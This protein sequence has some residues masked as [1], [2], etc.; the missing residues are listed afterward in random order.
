MAA[1]CRPG[2]VAYLTGGG[3]VNPAG[4]LATGG[5]APNGASS[6]ALP[7]SISV[8]GQPAT[9]YYLGLTPG[10][11]GLYQANFGSALSPKVMAS[12]PG[13]RLAYRQLLGRVAAIPGVRS[14]AIT[15]LV[16]L[17]VED[18]EIP[19]WPGAGPQPAQDRTTSAMFSIVTPDYPGA[20]H[21]PLLRGRFFTDQ[22]NLA[23]PPVVA[24][25][26]V[27]ARHVFGDRDLGVA[28]LGRRSNGRDVID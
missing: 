7:Y 22:D 15:S 6:A 4:P 16:P 2:V 14:A 24:I 26:E 21:I 11:V 3:P 28:T 20:M 8:G 1:I 25:D 9:Q 10:F 5:P 12:P 23:S 18:V 19:F 17:G 27:L 13:I